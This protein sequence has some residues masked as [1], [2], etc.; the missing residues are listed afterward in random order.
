ME[1]QK[2]GVDSSEK[3]KLNQARN[4]HH[5]KSINIMF[6]RR[7]GK[8]RSF[9]ISTWIVFSILLFLVFYLP[10]SILII[11]DYINLRLDNRTYT[12]QINKLESELANTR[13]ELWNADQRLT[14][15][16][17]LIEDM[18]RPE[19]K[20]SN[21]VTEAPKEVVDEPRARNT[22]VPKE[23]NKETKVEGSKVD[24]RDM[25]ITGTEARIDINFKL[26]NANPGADA[27][28][29]YIHLM[30]MADGEQIP[31]DWIYPKR[32]FENGFPVDY[33]RGLPF[34]IERFKPYKHEFQLESGQPTPTKVRILVYDKS[35]SIIL[36]ED[37]GIN[38]D[39]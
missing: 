4:S 14:L 10:V 12:Q 11:N 34:F 36:D 35:G 25:V 22:T 39:S 9:K 1:D 8:I 26:V 17:T 6:M 5:S 28:E 29:G 23:N 27:V 30:V 3:G 18:K 15:L 7:V 13:K 32:K 19:I 16:N 31:A 33:K 37:F 38:N 24:V 20:K 2:R 21:S